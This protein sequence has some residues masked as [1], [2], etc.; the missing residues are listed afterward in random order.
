[1]IEFIRASVTSNDLVG[2]EQA[3]VIDGYL[4]GLGFEQ[5]GDL[6]VWTKKT[7]LER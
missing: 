3:T 5:V 6:T 2:Y 7:P 4:A 1:M